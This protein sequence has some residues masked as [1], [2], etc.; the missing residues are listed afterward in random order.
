MSSWPRWTIKLCT[1]GCPQ[2]FNCVAA[3]NT[4]IQEARILVPLNTSGIAS[5]CYALPLAVLRPSKHGTPPVLILEPAI[6]VVSDR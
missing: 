2:Q 4:E 3:Q 1:H 5:V 6:I